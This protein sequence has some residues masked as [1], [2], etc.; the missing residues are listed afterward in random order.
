MRTSELPAQVGPPAVQEHTEADKCKDG[1][2]SDRE[3]QSAGGHVE[4]LSLHGPVDGGHGP[5]QTDTQE[6]IDSITAGDV[7]NGSICVHILQ[8]SSFA[9]KRIWKRTE[10]N[11]SCGRLRWA[12]LF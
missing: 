9:G 7:A 4:L 5:G 3:G 8:G 1:E 11:G 12:G 2:K 6:D 10:T